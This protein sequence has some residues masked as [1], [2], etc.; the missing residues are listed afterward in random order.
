MARN[1]GD[2]F[3]AGNPTAGFMDVLG[4]ATDVVAGQDL[5]YVGF[6]KH[7]HQLYSNTAWH[8]IDVTAAAGAVPA[9]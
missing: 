7:I 2:P 5:F 4:A 9:N 6:D 1:S 8:P 3:A